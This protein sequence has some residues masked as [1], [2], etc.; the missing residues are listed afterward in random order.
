MMTL[1]DLKKLIEEIESKV[2]APADRIR[3]T[4][5]PGAEENT[6]FGH[7][8]KTD[9]NG[10]CPDLQGGAYLLVYSNGHPWDVTIYHPK[11]EESRAYNFSTRRGAECIL[12]KGG[13]IEDVKGFYIG[14]L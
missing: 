2:G 1:K 13:T 12:H 5:E 6:V 10:T 4:L 7:F 11:T 8:I 14:K 3:V 9:E